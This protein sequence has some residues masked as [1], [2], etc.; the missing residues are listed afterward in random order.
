MV[1]CIPSIMLC[2]DF[3]IVSI[4]SSSLSICGMIA[5]S[6]SIWGIRSPKASLS[7]SM[8]SKVSNTDRSDQH[9]G[10][11][12]SRA[13]GTRRSPRSRPP[14][15]PAAAARTGALS[16]T[17]NPCLLSAR[18]ATTSHRTARI[19]A[20]LGRHPGDEDLIIRRM[21]ILVQIVGRVP[22]HVYR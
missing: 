13:S 22:T 21:R 1:L 16:S 7:V 9:T 18:Q 4:G 5:S 3:I 11:R 15:T 8:P 12:R 20:G 2:I 10:I 19:G 14:P 17:C 6:L